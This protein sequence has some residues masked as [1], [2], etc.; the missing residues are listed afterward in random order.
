MTPEEEV[1]KCNEECMKCIESFEK[2]G[3]TFSPTMCKYC[4]TGARLHELL[5]QTSSGEKVWDKQDW[6]SSKLK[7][8]YHG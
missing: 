1:K 6:G 4:P 8:L 3:I 5:I 2:D 7:P